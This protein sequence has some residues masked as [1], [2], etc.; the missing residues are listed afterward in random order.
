M[1]KIKNAGRK[2][3]K[4][5]RVL[6][7][8]GAILVPGIETEIADEIAAKLLERPIVK[9]LMEAGE[10]EVVEPPKS[11]EPPPEP[12][13]PPEPAKPAAAPAKA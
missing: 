2:A 7:L 11:A 8:G 1:A 4:S 3:E 12:P 9:A 13:K 6:H 10:I 5:A